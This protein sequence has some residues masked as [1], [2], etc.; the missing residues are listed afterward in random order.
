MTET[1]KDFA[2]KISQPCHSPASSEQPADVKAVIFDF[3]FT[4]ADSSQGIVECVS[5]ALQNL[6]F[7][8]PMA[9]NIVET[10]GLSLSETFRLCT[11]E[12]DDLSAKQFA[13]LFHKRADEIMDALTVVYDPVE[14]VMRGLREENISTAIVSTK[15]NY[16]IRSILAVN[17]LDKLIDVIVGADDVKNTKPDPEGLLLALQHLG[18]SPSSAVYVGDHVVDAEAARNA[19]IPFIAALTGMHVRQ[20]FEQYPHLAIVD[21]VRD[22]P[23]VLSLT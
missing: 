14:S 5:Y 15:L 22:V 9:Q 19:G 18:V 17:R 8:P 23:S 3:D 1:R 4:L 7:L 6:G 16:R 20:V 11:G 21:H 13:E 12:R 10:I 2:D